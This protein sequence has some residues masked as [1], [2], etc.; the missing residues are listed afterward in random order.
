MLFE[1]S[2]KAYIR[3]RATNHY[4]EQLNESKKKTEEK[5][6]WNKIIKPGSMPWENSR[7]GIIK[8]LFNEKMPVQMESIDAYMQVYPSRESLRQASPHVGRIHFCS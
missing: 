1:E 4:E 5:K 3:K 8:H 7:Q 2:K 6:G